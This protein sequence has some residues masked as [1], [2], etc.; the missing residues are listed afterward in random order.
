MDFEKPLQ[1]KYTKLE[2]LLHLKTHGFFVLE[3]WKKCKNKGIVGLSKFNGYS[4]LPESMN[5]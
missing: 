2:L 3:M 5:N 4:V 1:N